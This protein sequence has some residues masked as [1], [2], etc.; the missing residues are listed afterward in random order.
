VVVSAR[1]TLRVSKGRSLGPSFSEMT[2]TTIAMALTVAA[3]RPNV[4]GVFPHLAVVADQVP[5]RSEAGVGALMPW[6][7]RL[8]GIAPRS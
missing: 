1:D 6:V 2:L 3:E 7:S 8:A 5:A 4:D